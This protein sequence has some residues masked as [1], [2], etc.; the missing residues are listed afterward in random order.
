MHFTVAGKNGPVVNSSVH[1]GQGGVENA[2]LPDCELG[3]SV[4]MQRRR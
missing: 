4:S 2:A 1:V 3:H